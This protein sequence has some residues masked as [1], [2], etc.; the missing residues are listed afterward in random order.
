VQALPP[1]PTAVAFRNASDGLLGT[2]RGIEATRD[3]GR[4]WRVVFRTPQPV[5][6]L[7]Y[8][9]G[10][11]P[12]AILDD[13]EN[14][15]GP[16]WRPERPLEQLTPCPA[17]VNRAVR[18]DDWVLCIGQGSAGSGEK[19]V[20]RLTPNG[21][22]RLAWAFLGPTLTM[23]GITSQGYA[24]GLAM[25]HDG[26]GIIWQA[27]GPL[28][29]TRDGGSAWLGLPEVGIPEIDWGIS[30]AAL[31]HGVAWVLLARGNV[32]RRLLETTDRGRTW[33]VVHRWS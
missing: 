7:G 21:P 1:L 28:L 11:R 15:G 14:L 25:A 23:H 32:H 29:V 26:F 13:G 22:K 8:D 2:T 24:V 17:G 10:G 5:S 4:T 12:R 3:G 9:P 16:R 19:A 18:S 30:G 33:R 6:W 27:R 20:Y 31:R